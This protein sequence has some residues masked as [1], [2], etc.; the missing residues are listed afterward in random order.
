MMFIPLDGVY[1]IELYI[2]NIQTCLQHTTCTI[3]LQMA[4]GSSRE[5]IKLLPLDLLLQWASS[6]RAVE[7]FNFATNVP[8]RKKTHI[9]LH[10]Q[11]LYYAQRIRK[12]QG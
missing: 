8:E 6:S 5:I 10:P 4:I 9:F 7:R 1:Y 3:Q 11:S 2:F 12:Q